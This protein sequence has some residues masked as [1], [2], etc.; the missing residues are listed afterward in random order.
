MNFS[1]SKITASNFKDISLLMDE[2]L[3]LDEIITLL[4]EDAKE[5]ANGKIS[6]RSYYNLNF[7]KET[8]NKEPDYR[9]PSN[10][11]VGRAL[12]ERLREMMPSASL[13][14]FQTG[15]AEAKPEKKEEEG[16][17]YVIDEVVLLEIIA[18][19]SRSLQREKDEV[20]KKLRE[21][22]VDI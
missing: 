3:E 6:E 13:M 2:L 20:K 21:L 9:R 5:V 7:S 1:N 15:G 19:I 10:E 16:F 8:N 4:N 18:V 12:E 17:T 22:N 14:G 11:E